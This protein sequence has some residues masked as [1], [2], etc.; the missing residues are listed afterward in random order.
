MNIIVGSAGRLGSYLFDEMQRE[1]EVLGV[2]VVEGRTVD[3]IIT[4]NKMQSYAD[5]LREVLKGI[6]KPVRIILAVAP[7]WRAKGTG[8]LTSQLSD[9]TDFGS[10]ES[11]LLLMSA[12]ILAE[13][14]QECSLRHNIVVIGSPLSSSISLSESPI[15]AS[16]KSATRSL[17]KY[18]ALALMNRNV[19]VNMVT[20]ALLANN[21]QLLEIIRGNL[22]KLKLGFDV[23]PYGEILKTVLFISSGITSIRG[24]EIVLDYGLMDISSYW[25][26][27]TSSDTL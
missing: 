16:S 5:W 24:Q 6:K 2:D 15:Y 12:N 14:N 3:H 27:V 26:L 7:T 13:M 4:D 23:T 8:D 25:T 20:P 19:N 9:L 11:G 1:G 21:D 17:M 22:E 18:L 10:V